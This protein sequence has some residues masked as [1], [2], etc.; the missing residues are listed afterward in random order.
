[1]AEKIKDYPQRPLPTIKRLGIGEDVRFPKT[2]TGSIRS[3]L[4]NY[5]MTCL[6]R[7][8]TKTDHDELIVLR[9]ADAEKTYE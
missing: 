1:M 4:T 5:Q 2:R 7:F 9:I 6:R 8:E 3:M